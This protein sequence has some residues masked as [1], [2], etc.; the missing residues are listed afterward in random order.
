M[1]P[2]QL[3][4]AKTLEQ[5]H[6]TLSPDPLIT[7]DQL[8]AFYRDDLN[9]LR[10]ED[11]VELIAAPLGWAFGG[12]HFKAL[13]Y[14]HSGVG[15]STE[16]TRLIRKVGGQ[17]RD[18][19]FSVTRELDRGAFEPF[20][21]LL[22]MMTRIV[23]ETRKP[24]D[25]GGAG[26]DL[27]ESLLQSILNW[28]AEES[29]TRVEQV[30]TA[31]S[32]A[33][34]IGPPPSS[35]TAKVLGLFASIKGEIKYATNR[36]RKT[37][38]HRLQRIS[39]L[40]EL[41]NHLLETSNELLRKQ[42]HPERE[43]LF[44]GEDFDKS[45]IPPDRTDALFIN[46]ANIFEDLNTHLIFTVPVGMVYSEKNTGLPSLCGGLICLPDTP[47]FHR[48]HSTHSEGRSALRVVLEGRAAP[49]LFDEGEMERLIV[50][51]GGNLRDLF[52]MV[53]EAAL[54]AHLRKSATIGS[55]DADKAIAKLRTEYKRKLGQGPFDDD[56]ITYEEKAQRLVAI[57]HNEAASD[58]GSPVLHSLLN[59]RA[60]QEFN[61]ERWFGVH[62]LVVDVLTEQGMINRPSS[63][64][65]VPGG[66]R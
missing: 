4:Q 37:V 49:S 22:L 52:R 15:K 13:L 47:V 29:T 58:M 30:D 51:S 11:I 34:G 10:G 59:S 54:K 43:W 57:Y 7:F 32:A 9:P 16:L 44:I 64:G 8:D 56:T 2:L 12:A 26:K 50:A 65:A 60:V 25:A 31:V 62:P 48:D 5:I 66:T 27:P 38:E 35:I 21:I 3:T 41:L 46:Y 61:G 33:A 1:P 40:V 20:D 55:T 28:F 23:E 53:R 18:I 39:T 63:G 36:E 42:A 17:F 6:Q 45:G 19:R 14:G 24:V